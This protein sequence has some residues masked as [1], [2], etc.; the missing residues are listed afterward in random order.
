MAG[1]LG[2]LRSHKSSI[3]WT[4]VAIW[5]IFLL[6]RGHQIG[7]FK[8]VFFAHPN[9]IQSQY[10]ERNTSQTFPPLKPNEQII[11]STDLCSNFPSDMLEHVQIVMKT[12]V[13]QRQ[14]N[15][16]HFSSDTSCISNLIVVS[17][18]EEQVMGRHF[19]DVLAPLG[20]AYQ[21]HEDFAAYHEQKKMH[22]DGFVA[23]SQG[24]WK[25]DR[26]KF[27]PMVNLAWQKNPHARWYVF[28]EADVYIFWDNLF[29]LLEQMNSNDT[30]YLGSAAPGADHVWFAYGGAGI[31]LSHRL[32]FDLVGDGT[33]LSERFQ[34]WALEDCCGDAVLAYAILNKTGVRLE[35]LYPMFSGEDI[36]GMR[37]NEERW[38][39]P[40][41]SLHRMTEETLQS[42]WQWERTRSSSQVGGHLSDTTSTHKYQRPLSFADF[43]EYRQPFLRNS[44]TRMAWDNLSQDLLPVESE[45][46]DSAT[47]CR[48][49]C[50]RDKKC[51]QYS[52]IGNECR[53]SHHITLGHAVA[54]DLGF[55]SGWDRHKIREFGLRFLEDG[56]MESSCQRE[57][58]KRPEIPM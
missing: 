25:L 7:D 53:L 4:V 57:D 52:F 22:E 14:K 55:I 21:R 5:T 39:V 46:G 43:L 33:V 23:V 16:A 11:E 40:L 34:K 13:S 1:I 26:F 28:L 8:G 42:V 45:A 17:D 48:T 50:V 38:C 6:Y 2:V 41:I 35:N 24:G 3:V 56:H 18:L 54:G 37:I 32:M 36:E 30:H 12:G 31:V 29:R 47:E 9:D 20:P 49:A 27:L 15:E 19:V 51:L 58:W 10:Y 44:T